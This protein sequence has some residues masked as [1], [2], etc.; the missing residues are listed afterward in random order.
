MLGT[1]LGGWPTEKFGARRVLMTATFL[2][3]VAL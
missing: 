2:R 3:A 1:Y